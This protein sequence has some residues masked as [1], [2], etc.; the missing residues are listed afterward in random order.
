[1]TPHLDPGVSRR[2]G[3][4]VSACSLLAMVFGLWV[5]A[6]WALHSQ[7]VKSI[8]PGQVPVE[9]NTAICF[10]L[11]GFALW[12]LRKDQPAAASGWALAAKLAA[13]I[14]SM[15]GLLSLLE[16]MIGWDFGIDQLL[17][18]AG[19]KNV[20]GSAWPGLMSPLAAWGFFLLGPT[21]LLLDAKT[22]LGRWSTQLLPSVV[23]LAAMFGI[24]D[25][26]L[27][28]TATHT[29]SS[30]V[31]SLAL[32]VVSFGLMFARPQ[33]GLGALVTGP[34][35]GGTLTR[36]FF[37]AAILV[38]LVVGWLRWKKEMTG[39]YSDWS[40]LTWMTVLTVVLLA[41]LTAW[42]G[43]TVDRAERE[44]RQSQETVTRLAAIV[45]SSNDAIFGKTLEGIV[46]SWNPGAEAIYGYSA[47]EM[48]GHS[49]SVSVPPDRRE[50]FAAIMDRVKRGQPVE[51]HETTRLRKDGQIIHVSLGVSPVRDE[52]GR[53]VGA[54]TIARDIT[55]RKKAERELRESQERFRILF[56]EMLVGF[57]L[58]EPIYD[59]A[60]KPCDF[61]YL[62]VNPAFETHCGLGRDEV[63]GKTIR[64]VLPTLEPIWIA[65]YGKVAVTGESIHFESHA[66]PLERWLELSAFRTCKNQVAVTFA[67][68]SERK[69]AEEARRES[70]ERFQAMANGIPQLAW[71]AEPDGHIFWYNQRWY[72]YTGT[73]FEQ[74]EG[75]GWQSVHDPDVLP[76]VLM[77][78]KAAIAAGV[79]FDME[80]PLRGVDAVFRT[81]LTR[82]MPF[83]DSEG[84][85]TRWFGTNT[86]ISE[87]QRAE[88]EIHR[89]NDELEQRV[90]RR[91]AQLQAANQELEAFT[92]SV[93]HDLRAPLRHISGFS[94]IL[95]E[96]FGPKLPAEAQHH[97]QRIEQG[98]R[99]MGLL[100]DDL[101]KLARV[102]RSE[103]TLRA[104]ELKSLIDEVI[105]ELSPECTNRQIEWKIGN[106]GSVACDAGL[107][108]QV[109]QNLLSN[110]L[111]F[112]QPR[113]QAVIEVGEKSEAGSP[114]LFVRDNGVGFS[115]KYADK[116]FGVFQRLHRLEDFEGTG[117]GLATV[118]RI[119]EKHGGR[120]WAEA[121]PD[122]GATFSFTLGISE[123]SELKT[124]AATV[125]DKL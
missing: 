103:L 97:L 116:L 37:P 51:H 72:E 92:Y 115:M 36:R 75:W 104:T 86:D 5:L 21:L 125:G 81:F 15:V 14:A 124:K 85:V 63:V 13:A 83:K 101:L 84:R 88:E 31:S 11:I 46:T 99:R 98:T 122:K 17:F 2:L 45:T 108:K 19:A 106:L 112:T 23:A 16:F 119:V 90:Q 38:P 76:K 105:A 113:A 26:V 64:E 47:A 66:E 29:Y 73:T 67:D 100:V 87:R 80:F 102:G 109:F 93:S 59:E 58:L 65:T 20:A 117:V 41:S 6:G 61:R 68:I 53:I 77:G 1:M 78:W 79:P 91:T 10:I 60:G 50:D 3:Q 96:E 9:A 43:F 49:I 34:T 28:P 89:L 25:F 27:D 62:E 40:G 55:E 32:S 57:A 48:I 107:M 82:V 120:I 70:E 39:P 35:L 4:F 121:E 95:S 44:R 12:I 7:I 22:K 118:Q 42:T 54:S 114:I 71:M 30:P 24:L 74:M 111:K 18:A 110:A 56:D 123:N 94:K 8:L 33:W 52:A 69:R